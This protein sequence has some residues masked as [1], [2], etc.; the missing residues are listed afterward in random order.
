MK[1]QFIG[2]HAFGGMQ[3][4]QDCKCCLMTL[5][6]LSVIFILYVSYMVLIETQSVSE[7]I[8]SN[9]DLKFSVDDKV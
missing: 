7:K 3:L 1:G 9:C 4:D 2:A 8:Q 5:Q 6:Y